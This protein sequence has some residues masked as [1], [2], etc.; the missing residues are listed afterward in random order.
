MC[1]GSTLPENHQNADDLCC[2]LIAPR[3]NIVSQIQ[4]SGIKPSLEDEIDESN[5]KTMSSLLVSK[6]SIRSLLPNLQVHA[7]EQFD[8]GIL[9]SSA[10]TASFL[11]RA[12]TASMQAPNVLHAVPAHDAVPAHGA[13]AIVGLGLEQ[14]TSSHATFRETVSSEASE[15]LKR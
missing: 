5:A 9:Q 3:I 7:H 13:G 2:E 15:G 1:L 8:S 10:I 4:S 12:K 14:I 11:T 6:A